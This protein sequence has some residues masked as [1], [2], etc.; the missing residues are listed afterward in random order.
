MAAREGAEAD[1]EPAQASGRAQASGSEAGDDPQPNGP[2]SLLARL[3]SALALIAVAL[4]VVV[5]GGW[6]LAAFVAGALVV[7]SVEW[8]RLAGFPRTGA[9]GLLLGL[10]G[11]VT[12]L[13]LMLAGPE[14]A[15]LTAVTG[16]SMAGLA[17]VARGRDGF[18]ALFAGFYLLLPAI[19]FLWLRAEPDG[20]SWVLVLFAVV[21]STDSGAFVA[22]RAL[23]GPAFVPHVS[24]HKTWAG[25]VGGAVA[26]M[27]A[28]T[29]AAAL[30]PFADQAPQG[31]VWFAALSL[32]IAVATHAGDIFESGL[33]RHFGVKDSG[34]LIPGHG[35]FLD[36]L[37]GFLFAVMML[38]LTVLVL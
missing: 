26:G 20:L 14:A 31:L 9:D 10:A 1:A 8:A 19:A 24:P 36:R 18:Y 38:A 13:A 33:K 2:A 16:A 28:G 27:A 25:T 30:L 6:W 23:K 17:G 3:I 12:V 34:C 7:M 22:G 21:W 4:G 35:G 32:L 29:A 15:V 11:P 5:A 37:D